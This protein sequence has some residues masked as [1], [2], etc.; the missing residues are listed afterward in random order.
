MS[1]SAASCSA[2]RSTRRISE[3]AADVRAD[4][5]GRHPERGANKVGEFGGSLRDVHPAERWNGDGARGRRNVIGRFMLI[6]HGFAGAGRIPV[7]D[8]LACAYADIRSLDSAPLGND[9]MTFMFRVLVVPSSF[10]HD[11]ET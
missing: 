1:T 4:T 10:T 6:A 8:V 7:R 3:R 9:D 2:R 11:D 5:T